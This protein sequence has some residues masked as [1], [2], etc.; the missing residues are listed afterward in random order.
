LN[1][2]ED[3]LLFHF[4]KYPLMLPQDAVKLCFQSAFGCGHLIKNEEQALSMLKNEME[5][6][7]E[8]SRARL[9]ESIGSG[10]ARIDLCAA[11]AKNIP[12]EKICKVFIKS[13]ENGI[14]SDFEEKT[15]VLKNLAAAQKAPFSA[16][17]LEEY[18]ADYDGK[19]VSHTKEYKKAYAPAYRVICEKFA[20][21]LQ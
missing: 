21:D 18:L 10:Y 12:A 19:M 3:I 7:K 15:A 17:E 8:N 16:K 1:G 20:E 11:K 6:I 2:F 5:N 14:K 13:A 9:L 4:K